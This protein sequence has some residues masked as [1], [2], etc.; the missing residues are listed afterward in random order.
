MKSILTILLVGLMT[1]FNASR[2]SAWEFRLAGTWLWGYEYVD[3][4]GGAGFF[5]PHD[6]AT[7]SLSA[8]GM[9]KV[10]AMNAWVGA[11]TINSVQYGMVTG[12]DASLQWSRMELT[13]EIRFHDAIMLKGAY[14]IGN[15]APTEYGLYANS[16]AAGS[17]TP[18]ATGQWTQWWVKV[19]SPWGTLSAGKRGFPW[20]M[21]LQY[22][23]DVVT[24]ESFSVSVPY[25]PLKMC[26]WCYPWQGQSWVN[27]LAGRDVVSALTVVGPQI[28]PTAFGN[29]LDRY[30]TR[31]AQYRLWDN[32]RKRQLHPGGFITYEAGNVSMGVLYEWYSIHNG[33]A[34]A[35]NNGA[36]PDGDRRARTY[37]SVF[38][39]GSAYLK[40]FNGW[41]ALNAELAWIRCGTRIQKAA[42][43]LLPDYTDGR[44]S[45][46]KP[47]YTE[48]WKWALELSSLWGP[49]KLSLLWSW[50]PGPDRRAGVWIDRQSWENVLNGSYIPST[51]V[52]LPYSL[53]I[54]YQYGAGVMAIDGNGEGH[55]S[56]ANSFGARLD[57]AVASNLILYGTFFYADRVSGGWPWGILT[58]QA[59]GNGCGR[60][61]LLGQSQTP[62]EG[63]GALLNAPQ[64]QG[65]NFAPNIP[66]NSLGWEVTAGVD[67]KL[68]EGLTIRMRGA[69]WAV[70]D[71]FKFACIDKAVANTWNAPMALVVPVAGDGAAI[72]SGWG[73]N[74][75]KSIDPIWMFQSVLSVDF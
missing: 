30:D 63:L 70:G 2:A 10:N 66:D 14:Q 12:A 34:A 58:L 54:G 40:Y 62:G 6:A 27:S 48:T 43:E 46:F 60:V 42:D 26:V 41:F 61:I 8:V 38:E 22:E 5:G 1:V 28:Q 18:L 44:G 56:D 9:P 17:W 73:I 75:A 65:P 64:N 19:Q 16:T 74:P 39:D 11:R 55:M 51:H 21:G 3:Q 24:T 50:I 71:W 15:A 13:P 35:I 36:V 4:A 45:R 32:D 69:Y 52:H 37:D 25:G 72:G 7:A 47:T 49:A 57:Y 23:G 67:W 68:L 20:G 53:L 33:P 59:D 29:Q 31:V